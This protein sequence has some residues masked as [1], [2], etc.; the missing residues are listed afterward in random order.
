MA[1]GTL[2]LY[3][4]FNAMKFHWTTEGYDF[5]KF[6][7]KLKNANRVTLDQSRDRSLYYRLNEKYKDERDFVLTIIPLFLDNQDLHVSGMLQGD[8]AGKKAMSW[9][10][11]IQRMPRFFADDCDIITKYIKEH[12]MSY[13]QFFYGNAVLDMVIMD[14]VNLETFII[15]DKCIKFLTNNHTHNI[16]FDQVY[17]KKAKKYSCFINVDEIKY[18]NIFEKSIKKSN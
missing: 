10:R 12:G 7:G 17:R 3:E 6:K 1:M 16:M 9:Y 18:K 13:Q 4:V 14:V 5:I 8:E 11:K 15:L 2:R